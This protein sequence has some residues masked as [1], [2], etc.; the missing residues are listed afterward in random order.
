MRWMVLLVVMGCAGSSSSGDADTDGP[1]DTDAPPITEGQLTE[2][3]FREEFPR[4]WIAMCEAAGGMAWEDHETTGGATIPVGTYPA[5]GCYNERLY[6]SCAEQL[7]IANMD[8]ILP[9]G[10]GECNYNWDEALKC[11]EGSETGAWKC[12]DNGYGFFADG[13][14]FVC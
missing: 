5:D 9:T 11:L 6:S 3:Y 2:E 7:E 13:C 12:S 10:G 1:A 14:E 8:R 4:R